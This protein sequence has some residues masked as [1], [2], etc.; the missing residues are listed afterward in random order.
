V[1]G[2]MRRNERRVPIAGSGSKEG[3]VD[4]SRWE[5]SRSVHDGQ[6]YICRWGGRSDCGLNSSSLLE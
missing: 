3:R 1:S 6:V 4:V 5:S 2:K